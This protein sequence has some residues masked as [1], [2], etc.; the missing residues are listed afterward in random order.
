MRAAMPGLTRTRP[1]FR[2]IALAEIP[3]NLDELDTRGEPRC[4]IAFTNAYGN[5][6]RL[7][8]KVGQLDD[9][10]TRQLDFN[11]CHGSA[12]TL[13]SMGHDARALGNLHD[14]GQRQHRPID[15]ALAL[16][17]FVLGQMKELL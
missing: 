11:S 5:E 7:F 13:A 14:L 10:T 6:A 4:E 1:W 2:A 16:R 12:L 17:G 3:H 9:G 15:H 8:E